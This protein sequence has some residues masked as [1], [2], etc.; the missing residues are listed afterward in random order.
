MDF[1]PSYTMEQSER[2]EIQAQIDSCVE[3]LLTGIPTEASDYEKVK[4]VFE[5]LIEQVDYNPEAEN[6]QNIIS[7][8][9]N[10]GNGLSGICLCNAVSVTSVEYPM[11]DCNRKS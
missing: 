4:Y 1:S 10:G 6:N 8:F 7:V 9:L 5:T 11:Y 2:E 3:E